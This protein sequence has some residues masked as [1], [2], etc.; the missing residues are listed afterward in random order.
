MTRSVNTTEPLSPATPVTTQ[1]VHEQSGHIGRD[2]GYTW[3][4]Q[5]RLPLA[6][7]DLATATAEC[8]ICQKQR[9]TL[10]P[11]YGTI[12]WGDQPATWW[13]ADYTGPVP[14][15]KGQ[16]SFLTGIDTYSRYGFAYPAHNASAKTT[17]CRLME[18]L[19]HCHSIPH[20]IFSDQGTHFTA[21]EVQ[22]WACAHGIHWFYH[23][24]HH[25][26]AARLTEQWNGLLKSQ[27]QCQLGDNTLQGGGKVLQEAMYALSQYPIYGTVSSITRI[28]GSRNQGVEVE[29]APLTITPSDPLAKFLL[30]VP[31]ALHSAGLEVLVPEG[32][33]L[34]PGDTTTIPL[35]WKLR[36]PPGQFGLLLP[37]SQQAEKEVTVLAGV[38]YPDYQDKIS[39]L[40]H[41]GGKKE[42]AWNTGDPLGHL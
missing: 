38:I 27:L 30:P 28:H 25:P 2:G 5:H 11:R 35:N 23:V 40:L 29:V 9:P 24:P 33:T 42:Y 12:P 41:N 1:W 7:D 16:R 39:L 3:T 31:M 14:S 26:E 15:W 20:S 34:Q 19:I 8:P 6:K 10:N 22:Q 18:C 13:Q 37:L 21:K 36:L 4:Q 17:I 32:G